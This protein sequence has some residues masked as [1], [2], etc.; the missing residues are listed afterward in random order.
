MLHKDPPHPS[1]ESCAQDTTRVHIRLP[2]ELIRLPQKRVEGL[3][4]PLPLEATAETCKGRHRL[5]SNHRP[6]RGGTPDTR[7]RVTSQSPLVT[8][9]KP[10]NFR[11]NAVYHPPLPQATESRNSALSHPSWGLLQGIYHTCVHTLTWDSG[12]KRT[13]RGQLPA[14]THPTAA[15][16]AQPTGGQ[17]DT[18]GECACNKRLGH[19]AGQL[20]K[21]V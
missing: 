6:V 21:S 19:W 4:S 8:H 12:A 2:D 9:V 3:A 14:H 16:Q 18:R 15:L 13:Q 17:D 20:P 10:Q 11:G 1:P 7:L 5:G